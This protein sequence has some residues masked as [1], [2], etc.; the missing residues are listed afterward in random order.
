MW[1][2]KLSFYIENVI[3]EA[4]MKYLKISKVYPQ[5]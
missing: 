1:L 4:K 5:N 2:Q 3:F